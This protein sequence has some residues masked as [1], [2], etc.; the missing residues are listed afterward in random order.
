VCVCDGCGF[1]DVE[2]LISRFSRMTSFAPPTP[3]F[4]FLPN[5]SPGTLITF[6][7]LPPN[8]IGGLE[9]PGVVVASK[10]RAA[11]AAA[12]EWDLLSRADPSYGLKT[13]TPPPTTSTPSTSSPPTQSQSQAPPPPPSAAYGSDEGA[14]PPPSPPSLMDPPPT[15]DDRRCYC[16]VRRRQRGGR[17]G[18][19]GPGGRR[20][21]NRFNRSH[22]QPWRGR[23]APASC[24]PRVQQD[25]PRTCGGGGRST[26]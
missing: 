16:L 5:P 21:G 2:T 11:V 17:G 23:R 25:A 12:G 7:I 10:L 13:G 20:G 8:G 24:Y 3:P 9:V 1:A 22:C 4:G 19:G 15:A 26:E 18:R 6:R 14:P